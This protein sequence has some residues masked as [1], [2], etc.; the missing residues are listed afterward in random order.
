MV[1]RHGDKFQLATK[2]ED[3]AAIVAAGKRPVFMSVEN[4]QPMAGDLTLMQTFY[5]LGVRMMGPIHFLNNDLGDSATDPKGA[6]WRGLSPLGKQYVA[7][8]N[9][10]GILLDASHASDEVLEQMIALSKTPI[11]LSHSGVKAVY[12]HP[13]NIDDDH[14]RAL[15]RSGGVIQ[16]LAFTNYMI[17]VPR[18]PER[19]AA[20]AALNQKYGPGPARTEAQRRAFR[21]EMAAID[22]RWPLPRATFEDFK[23]HL[24]HALEVAGVDHV[25]VGA[26]F[27]GGGGVVGF[28]D[29]TG[30]PKITE[31]LLSKGYSREDI[32]KIWSGNVLRVLAQAQAGADRTLMAAL[33][34]DGEAVHG[35]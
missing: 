13:R 16:L 33:E 10:L 30:Y 8:A 20:V 6:E 18:I 27:D 15:A 34:G 2:P 17:D 7:E 11:I 26:D 22:A 24:D 14:L 35:D 9:R 12:D 25:G 32:G 23:K 21:T 1:A 3:A 19:A 4:S 31:Y 28:D 5:R 29:A